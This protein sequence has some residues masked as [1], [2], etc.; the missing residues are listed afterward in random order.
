MFIDDQLG[1]TSLGFFSKLGF[2]RC[3]L[4]DILVLHLN[5]NMYP[6]C[7]SKHALKLPLQE[8]NGQGE[9]KHPIKKRTSIFPIFH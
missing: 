2:D 6:T 5:Q 9:A 3:M 1:V 7:E 4:T 8:V